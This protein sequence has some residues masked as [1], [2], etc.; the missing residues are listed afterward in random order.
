[1]VLAPGL[2]FSA[3][4]SVYYMARTSGY[5]DTHQQS[6]NMAKYVRNCSSSQVAQSSAL[7][8]P[9]ESSPV[10]VASSIYCIT[11]SILKGPRMICCRRPSLL[12]TVSPKRISKRRLNVCQCC[13]P[14]HHFGYWTSCKDL[15]DDIVS[16]AS[17]TVLGSTEARVFKKRVCLISEASEE[18]GEAIMTCACL[19]L[20]LIISSL[21]LWWHA[22]NW[23]NI[24]P[25]GTVNFL[26][27]YWR[28]ELMSN[29][30]IQ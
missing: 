14:L 7:L 11:M 22:G 19:E 23:C 3:V 8:H 13:S 27:I 6:S 9:Q 12:R 25:S 10:A 15:V 30:R 29:W 28:N 4:V 18:S 26:I 2:R 24:H 1:M 21:Y 17:Q 20:L 16:V 5:Q